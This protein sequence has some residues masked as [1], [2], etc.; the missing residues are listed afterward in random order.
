MSSAG[1]PTSPGNVGRASSDCEGWPVGGDAEAQQAGM[2]KAAS[3]YFSKLRLS[4]YFLGIIMSISAILN[5]GEG[6][7]MEMRLILNYVSPHAAT[8]FSCVTERVAL[9]DPKRQNGATAIRRSSVKVGLV[10][11]VLSLQRLQ[12]EVPMSLLRALG[13]GFTTQAF[14]TGFS[15]L[16]HGG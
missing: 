9:H 2:R 12:C 5:F 4:R 10:S 7:Y 6:N 11:D 3:I 16:R 15:I 13:R 14:P 8:S 1:Q